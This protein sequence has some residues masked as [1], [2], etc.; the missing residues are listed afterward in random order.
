MDHAFIENALDED[1]TTRQAV[2]QLSDQSENQQPNT[3]WAEGR[4]RGVF[5]VGGLYVAGAFVVLQLGEIVLPAFNAPD[6][7]LQTL[8]VFVFLGLPV[9]LAFSWVYDLSTEGLKRTRSLVPVGGKSLVPGL[10]LLGVTAVSVALGIVW[11]NRTAMQSAEGGG[12]PDTSAEGLATFAALDP[13]APITAIAVLPLAHFAEGDDLFARQLHDEI[14]T[15]LSE[16]TSLRVVSRT[17]VERY[18][19][20]EKL[21]PEIA[22]EL[23]VQAIVTGSVAMT[24]ES[25]SVR[26]SIQL[27]HAPSDSLMASYTHQREMK[28]I[29]RLQTEVAI[30]IAGK[31]QGELGV[32]GTEDVAQVAQVDPEAYVAFV[33]GQGELEHGTPEGLQAALEHFDQAID[34][35]STYAAAWVWRA[36]TRMAMS[37]GRPSSQVLAQARADVEHANDLGGA[38][39]EAAAVMIAIRDYL[40]RGPRPPE[41]PNP[42]TPGPRGDGRLADADPD[43]LQRRYLRENTRFGRRLSQPSPLFS[44]FR[45]VEGGRYDSAAVVFAEIVEENPSMVPAWAALEELHLLQ[46]DYSAAVGVREDW[47]YAVQGRTDDTR[48]EVRTLRVT[49][50]ADDPATYWQWRRDRNTKWQARGE[51]ISEV[52]WATTAVGLGDLELALRH[53]DAALENRDPALVSL[54]TNAKWDPLRS[55]PA[56]QELLGKAR[57]LW[58]G[59]GTGGRRGEGGGERR[60]R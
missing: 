51:R 41:G 52:E 28:D 40:P 58:R 44:A 14:I 22:A 25:D 49:V 24:G 10:A 9:A 23:R 38:R 2:A 16:L 33:R 15:R 43:S 31:V 5:R 12:E 29:L 30:D 57:E 19:T 53:L 37:G 1:Q 35:D 32:E 17:S 26:I 56:F 48:E 45:L 39:E 59:W 8:V 54:R 11:F 21:L 3:F 55:D 7:A 47:I 6:W 42:A 60:P 34:Q 20:T 13:A 18:R 36:G 4:R 50:D 27:L 46:G